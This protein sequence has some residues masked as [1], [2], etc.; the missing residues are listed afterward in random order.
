M[1]SSRSSSGAGAATMCFHTRVLPRVSGP[2]S[3]SVNSILT[4]ICRHGE[5]G[6]RHRRRARRAGAAIVRR[7]HGSC[8]RHVLR[9]QC[10]ADGP[11]QLS[12]RGA[13][14]VDGL[15]CCCCVYALT[16]VRP[17]WPVSTIDGSDEM[18][19]G[20]SSF[21]CDESPHSHPALFKTCFFCLQALTTICFKLSQL[22]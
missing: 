15:K 19:C 4:P 10:A 13:G 18:K 21:P 8:R 20:A 11:H 3:Q 9:R 17:D 12:P 16:V 1:A 2:S 5:G 22:V 14:G 6:F 7:L